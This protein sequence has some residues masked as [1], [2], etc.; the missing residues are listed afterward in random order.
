MR[1]LQIET[2]MEKLSGGDGLNFIRILW[3]LQINMTQRDQFAW[4]FLIGR[5]KFNNIRGLKIKSQLQATCPHR[6]GIFLK[7]L[8]LA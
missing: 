5:F 7:T 6:C 1:W 3:V 4:R 8:G 2:H